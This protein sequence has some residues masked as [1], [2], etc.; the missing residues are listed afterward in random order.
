MKNVKFRAWHKKLKRMLYPPLLIDSMINVR[1][2]KPNG[3][4]IHIKAEPGWETM[5]TCLSAY[6]TWDGRC[7][8]GGTYQDLEWMMLTPWK[9]RDGGEI[10]EGDILEWKEDVGEWVSQWETQKGCVVW[11]E[12]DGGFRIQENLDD[13]KVRMGVHSWR[14]E[15]K[16]I[17][18]IYENKNSGSR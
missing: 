13:G 11:S 14:K 18:N 2:D 16:V 5:P 1:A 12:P 10:Y 17:G 6:M 9:D 8:H 15:Y 4:W 7:Y 3:E